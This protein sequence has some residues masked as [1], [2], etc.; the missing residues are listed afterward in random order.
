MINPFGDDDDDFEVNNMIDRNL[1]ISYLIV[2]IMHDDHPELLKDQYWDEIP[3]SLP[4]R[5]RV[6]AKDFEMNHVTD[7]FDV[8]E[9]NDTKTAPLVQHDV[10]ENLDSSSR[11]SIYQVRPDQKPR[12]SVID[13]SYRRV[14]NVEITQSH[15]QRQMQ[16]AREKVLSRQISETS[17]ETFNPHV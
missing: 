2:D 4:D 17:T 8:T 3:S 7:F 10:A 9:E 16:R 13:E 11:F 14:S 1:I 15:L 5:G 6:R 12:S